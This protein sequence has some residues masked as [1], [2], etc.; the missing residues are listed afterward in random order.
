MQYHAQSVLQLFRGH[1]LEI[2]RPVSS[3]GCRAFVFP[4]VGEEVIQ[5]PATGVGY[6]LQGI[7]K[8]H[9]R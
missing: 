6:E 3:E 8:I 9:A 2:E 1:S 4:S 7:L 5:S